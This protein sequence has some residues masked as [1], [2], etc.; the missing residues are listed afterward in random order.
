MEDPAVDTSSG[1]T[2]G[3]GGGGSTSNTARMFI[4]LKP[5]K[6]R[7]ASATQIIARLRP[8]LA[9]VPGAATFLQPVQDV[10]VG[11]RS[12]NAEFQFTL[13]GDNLADLNFWAPRLLQ[14]Q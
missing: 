1:F 6:E 2:G 4:S 5:L 3:G 14:K 10:R 9:I 13:Q 7:K 12:S 11:G 8:K